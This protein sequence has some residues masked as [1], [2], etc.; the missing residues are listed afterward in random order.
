MSAAATMGIPRLAMRRNAVRSC[1]KPHV[2]F[3][4]ATRLS[5]YAPVSLPSAARLPI[6][7]PAAADATLAR[8]AAEPW[9]SAKG[10]ATAGLQSGDVTNHVDA[11]VDGPQHIGE[12]TLAI[13]R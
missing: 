13:C 10:A 6:R 4:R 11:V 9:S 5:S 12:A 1:S 3:L 8:Q 2:F 7:L